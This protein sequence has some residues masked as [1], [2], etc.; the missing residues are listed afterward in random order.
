MKYIFYIV[1]AISVLVFVGSIIDFV[2]LGNY[3]ADLLTFVTTGLP[4][5]FRFIIGVLDIILSSYY[6]R[7]YLFAIIFFIIIDK[8]INKKE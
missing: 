2:T 7:L 3:I 5:P 1:I 4:Y 8:L 6:L